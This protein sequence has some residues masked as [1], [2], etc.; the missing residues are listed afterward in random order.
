MPHALTEDTSAEDSQ[1]RH[2]GAPAATAGGLPAERRAPA[3][4]ESCLCAADEERAA[5]AP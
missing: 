4:G 1:I 2:V 3:A 5:P